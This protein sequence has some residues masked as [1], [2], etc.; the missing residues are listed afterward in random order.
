MNKSEIDQK[1]TSELIKVRPSILNYCRSIITDPYAAEDITQ[2]TI[3]KILEKRDIYDPNKKLSGWAFAIC[4]FQ[5]KK[6]L[7]QI[8]RNKLH[9]TE[10]SDIHTSKNRSHQA[11][12]TALRFKESS[13]LPSNMGPDE[14]HVYNEFNNIG[15]DPAH[16]IMEE[17]SQEWKE[18]Y[19]N[20]LIDSLGEQSKKFLNLY[21]AGKTRSSIMKTLNISQVTYYMTKRRII[22]N[23]LKKLPYHRAKF[24]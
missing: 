14:H 16:G 17:E 15:A 19:L 1:L 21:L 22:Q 3:I 18:S 8:K 13:D 7:K 9:L 23:S 5:I 12:K 11:R 4:K 2:N 10:D 20:N 6:Y 24:N